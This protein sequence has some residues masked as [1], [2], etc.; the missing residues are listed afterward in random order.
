MLWPQMTMPRISPDPVLAACD[1]LVDSVPVT[2]PPTDTLEKLPSSAVGS[3]VQPKSHSGRL[4]DAEPPWVLPSQ[5][6]VN[7]CASSLTPSLSLV[8]AT[9]VRWRMVTRKKLSLPQEP[10]S[11]GD[12]RPAPVISPNMRRTACSLTTN[13]TVSRTFAAT[14]DSTPLCS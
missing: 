9:A 2:S 11:S 12:T 4:S 3:E 10:R 13:P 7:R 8:K 14:L 1:Q 5:I 6:L